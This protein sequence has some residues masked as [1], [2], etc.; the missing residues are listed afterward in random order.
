[1]DYEKIGKITVIESLYGGITLK[2]ED[3]STVSGE[4][5]EFFL[6]LN[7]RTIEGTAPECDAFLETTLGRLAELKESAKS[8]EAE[9]LTFNEEMKKVQKE[10]GM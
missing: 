10:L 7:S 5:V 1:M 2:L 9:I 8:I 6:E 3:L 4:I